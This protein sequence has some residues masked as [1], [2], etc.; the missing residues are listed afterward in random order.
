MLVTHTQAKLLYTLHGRLGV[1]GL[2]VVLAR[3]SHLQWNIPMSIMPSSSATWWSL[4]IF[5]VII[6]LLV[7]GTVRELWN[8]LIQ[9]T[10]FSVTLSTALSP[11][12][13]APSLIPGTRSRPADIYI[14]TWSGGRPAAFDV[15]VISTMQITRASNTLV[16][17][18]RWQRKGN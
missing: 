11:R 1:S 7:Q 3:P 15:T 8:N 18:L 5:S 4:K 13:K 2:P 16:T 17:P 12:K 9:D 6:R 10:I 14:P